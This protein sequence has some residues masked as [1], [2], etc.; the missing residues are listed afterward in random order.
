MAFY[1]L[2]RSQKVPCDLETI[3]DFI[4]RP[5]NL[6]KITPGHMGFVIRTPD[7]P[8]IIYPGLIIEYTV[9]PVA[10]IP[11]RWVTEITHVQDKHYFV[12]EQR[13][14]PYSMWHHEHFLEPIEGGVEMIDIISYSPPLGIL[15]KL[16][17]TLIIRRQLE[18]IFDYRKEA[19]IRLFGEFQS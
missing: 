12:D 5:E 18:H 17:N 7:L 13:I 4:S 15:G 1:Q 10:G 6:E 11:L 8:K 3:W 16:A 14:G 9:S 2:R 19:M